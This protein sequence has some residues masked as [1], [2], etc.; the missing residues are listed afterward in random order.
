M[1]SGYEPG[2]GPFYGTLTVRP[3]PGRDD[4]FTTEAVFSSPDGGPTTRR[5][6]RSTV[7]TGYQWRGRS[8]VAATERTGLREVM[9]WSRGWQEM[10]GR[11]FTGGY[12]E[13]GMDVTLAG[14]AAR[15]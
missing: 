5:T 13:I 11:W 1:L 15:R 2:R 10:S 14:S 6:G 8:N 4:E 9:S 12:D 3:V 7:Y